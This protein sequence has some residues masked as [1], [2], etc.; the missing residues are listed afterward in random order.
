MSINKLFCAV[1]SRRVGE[2]IIGNAL[3]RQY[4]ILIE[5]APP[6]AADAL[7]SK[8]VPRELKEFQTK[9]E[10]LHISVRFLFI[11]NPDDYQ[12]GR[13]RLI[14]FRESQDKKISYTRQEFIFSH[15]KDVVPLLEKYLQDEPRQIQNPIPMRDIL[16]CTHGSQD[17][18]CAKY[19]NPFY[20]QA[21]ATIAD[22]SLPNV[23]VWQ[24]S[25]FGGHRFA[26]TM[27]DFPEARYYGRLDQKSF[28]SILT[29][30]GDINCL[31]NVYRGWGILPWQV[32]F[33]ERELLLKYGWDWFNYQ[34]EGYVLQHNED[35]TVNQVEIICHQP[36]GKV[37][38][39][40]ANIMEDQSKNLIS[41]G[42]CNHICEPCKYP[43]FVVRDIITVS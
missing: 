21:K 4:Y 36:A 24:S 3:Y 1:E 38:T 30:T 29:R 13:Q 8:L 15:I 10:N 17:K 7:D 14:I 31:K 37:I 16:V 28:L 19:G 34:V 11:Y 39:Y 5:F 23:R 26:P 42:D 32:Q 6:W 33:L 25:H 40:R 20:R 35:E 9:L 18:C 2:D 12:V 27:I 43:Q 22:L 41:I